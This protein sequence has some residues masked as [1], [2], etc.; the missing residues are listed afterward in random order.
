MKKSCWLLIFLMVTSLGC[1]REKTHHQLQILITAPAIYNT[2][3][4]DVIGK[5]SMTAIPFPVIETSI[6]A[7]NASIDSVLI[8]IDEYDWI[9]LPSRNAIKAFFAEAKEMDMVGKIKTA[10]YCAIGKD[11]EY[12]K[13]FGVTDVLE[14]SEASPQGI[15]NALKSQ[16]R[17]TGKIAVLVPK[18]V[19]MPEPD[20][21]PCFIDSLTADAWQVTRVDAYKTTVCQPPNASQILKKI[22]RGKV[23]LIAFTSTAEI[24]ALLSLVGGKEN[25]KKVTVACFGPYTYTNAEKLG[26]NPAFMAKDYSSFDGFVVAIKEYFSETIP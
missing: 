25:L 12:L 20:V 6:M 17:R 22:K 15:A 16:L 11:Q 5:T 13:S 24:Q 18:V 23:D 10:H 26:L 3:L 9:V 19:G 7:H 14:N 21:V 1:K 4:C 2:R 8:G